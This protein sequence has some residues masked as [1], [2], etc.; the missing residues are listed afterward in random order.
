MGFGPE[1]ASPKGKEGG[2]FLRMRLRLRWKMGCFCKDIIL[3]SFDL[4][5]G[6]EIQLTFDE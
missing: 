4:E 6:E 1:R 2:V 5:S 3:C